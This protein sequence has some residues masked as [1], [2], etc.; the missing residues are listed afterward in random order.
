MCISGIDSFEKN[1]KSSVVWLE[2]HFT[3]KE[4]QY[5]RI[6]IISDHNLTYTIQRK[7]KGKRR[8][9]II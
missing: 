7:E 6:G 9:V 5:N 3:I 8:K 1:R 2:F 4:K